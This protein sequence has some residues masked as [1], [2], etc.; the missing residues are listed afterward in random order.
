MVKKSIFA[1]DLNSRK[2]IT[3]SDVL[4]PSSLAEGVIFFEKAF[5]YYG[6]LAVLQCQRDTSVN[7]LNGRILHVAEQVMQE[8]NACNLI[9]VAFYPSGRGVLPYISYLIT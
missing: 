4:L 3:L 8:L 5:F 7:I 2:N 9:V 6:C 1:C